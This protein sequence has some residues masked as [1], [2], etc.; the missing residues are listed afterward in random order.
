MMEPS[1][2]VR[3]FSG[4]QIPKAADAGSNGQGD[5]DQQ[6][7]ATAEITASF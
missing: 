4:E 2:V 3:F 6:F 1:P 5:F 7:D